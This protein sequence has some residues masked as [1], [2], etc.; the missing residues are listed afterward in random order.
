MYS[1][2]LLN[3]IFFI[4]LL[5][6]IIIYSLDEDKQAEERANILRNSERQAVTAWN[7][8]IIQDDLIKRHGKYKLALDES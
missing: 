8:T 6:S 4:L 2:L 3:T 7:D 1:I 5:L